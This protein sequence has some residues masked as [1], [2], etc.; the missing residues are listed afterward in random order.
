MRVTKRAA[1]LR[2]SGPITG[3]ADQDHGVEAL[4]DREVIGGAARLAAQPLE[5]EDRDALEALGHVQGA[6]AAD[7]K[8]LARHI[9]AVLD[10]IVGQLEE[11]LDSASVAAGP[12]GTCQVS[13]PC[14]R[15]RR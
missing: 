8:L 1:S 2:F 9:G 3:D 13:T 4:G 11:G 5:G 10:R 7:R 14:R 6:A 15:S 12:F